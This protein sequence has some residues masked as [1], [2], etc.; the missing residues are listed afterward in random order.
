MLMARWPRL[1]FADTM[2]V[3]VKVR[4]LIHSGR[5]PSDKCPSLFSVFKQ[6]IIF[7]QNNNLYL[8][9][10]LACGSL[11]KLEITSTW[12]I[13]SMIFGSIY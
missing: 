8:F 1:M 4:S 9:L 11:F 3:K 7:E 5:C 13:S 6:V 2:I 12:M 10:T